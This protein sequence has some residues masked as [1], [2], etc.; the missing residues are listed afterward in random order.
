MVS[1]E[2][3]DVYRLARQIGGLVWDVVQTWGRFERDTLGKQ[4][5]RSADSV[6]ANIAEG[7]GRGSAREFRQF[8]NV[9]RGSLYETIHWLEVST[10]RGLLPERVAVELRPLIQELLPKLAGLIRAQT[11]KIDSVREPPF[12]YGDDAE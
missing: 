6:A 1:F 7:A 5:S 4:V 10:E 8:L 2:D 9:A 12:L 3:L 11:R